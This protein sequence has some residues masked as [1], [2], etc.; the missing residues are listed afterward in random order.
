MLAGAGIVAG[1]VMAAIPPLLAQAKVLVAQFPHYVRVLE[2]HN[3]DVGRLNARF[4]VQEQLT[5]LLSSRGNSLM[6]GVVGAAPPSAG[7]WSRWSRC[8]CRYR[9]PSP[10]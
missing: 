8:R 9:W 5:H 7:W 3:S 2:S 6:G 1:F 10:P 4:H